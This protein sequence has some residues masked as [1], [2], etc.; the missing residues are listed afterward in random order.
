MPIKLINATWYPSIFNTSILIFLLNLNIDAFVLGNTIHTNALKSRIK[1]YIKKRLLNKN[2]TNTPTRTH[3]HARMRVQTHLL[4][5]TLSHVI[6][7]N[8]INIQI[9]QTAT[10]FHWKKILTENCPKNQLKDEGDY[11][12]QF[13]CTGNVLI[14]DEELPAHTKA[15]QG[16]KIG[17]VKHNT[18][19]FVWASDWSEWP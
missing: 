13:T 6:K 3:M 14:P 9:Q 12:L 19:K 4:S 16:G 10:R 1:N 5:L 18:K 11:W 17:I 15:L 2:Q 8:I 7:T